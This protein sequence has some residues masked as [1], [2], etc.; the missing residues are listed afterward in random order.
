MRPLGPLTSCA[1]LLAL[2]SPLAAQEAAGS[3]STRAGVYTE[4]QAQRGKTLYDRVCVDCHEMADFRGSGF[5][6]QWVGGTVYDLYDYLIGTMP[7]DAPGS[8]S[9]SEYAAAVAFIL[10]A[11]GF[12]AGQADL[13]VDEARL[14][15]IRFEA[16]A[17]GGGR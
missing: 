12:P 11:N 16:P 8:R 1:L 14:K 10:R 13:A 5:L 3:A 2:A 17:A 7:E 15:A 4:A 6:G 9:P